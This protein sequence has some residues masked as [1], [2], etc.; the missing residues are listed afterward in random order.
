MIEQLIDP[1]NLPFSVALALMLMLALV[2]LI[3]LGDIIGGEG[4]LDAGNDAMAIDAGLFLSFTGLG[5]LPFP[6]WLMLFLALFGL[7]GLSGQQLM[8]AL[9]GSGITAWLAAPLAAIA[10]LPITGRMARPLAAVLPHDETTAVS[11]DTLI[12]RQGEITIG[13][14]SQGDPAR[15][16]VEDIYG[17]IHHVMVEPDNEGQYFVQ[18]EKILLVR[19]EGNLFKA[20]GRGD[21]YLPRPD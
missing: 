21:H 13:T 15:A 19:R 14:A 20:I 6:M 8:I 16:H 11:V 4:D 12:G 18:G 5:R 17:H 10:A 3:G 9:T 7:I 1:H 2:Q